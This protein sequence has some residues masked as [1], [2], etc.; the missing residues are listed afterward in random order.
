MKKALPF[1]SIL[2]FFA[3]LFSCEPKKKA[4]SKIESVSQEYQNPYFA[5]TARI[6][7]IKK[8]TS[9]VCAIRQSQS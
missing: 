2:Y 6:S 8:V 9:V 7:K 4:T 5:D 3:S 1:L